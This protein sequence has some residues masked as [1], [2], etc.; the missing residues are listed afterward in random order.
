MT[1]DYVFTLNLVMRMI[2]VQDFEF[3][4]LTWLSNNWETCN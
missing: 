3:K 4:N 2:D 1:L